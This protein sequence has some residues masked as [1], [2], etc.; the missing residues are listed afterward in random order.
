MKKLTLF[1]SEKDEWYYQSKPY[2]NPKSSN[3]IYYELKEIRV[4][5]SKQNS[6]QSIEDNLLSEFSKEDKDKIIKVLGSHF[7]LRIGWSFK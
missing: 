1:D 3:S 4:S 5:L 7:Q 6:Y 2:I